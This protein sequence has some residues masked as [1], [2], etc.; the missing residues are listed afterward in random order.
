MGRIVAQVEVANP[1]QPE[2][3]S[4]FDALV[5]TGAS[6]L[7]LP[8]AW[9]DRLGQF[10]ATRTVKLEVAD[11]REV[12]GEVCGPVKIQIEGFDPIFSEV[13]FLDMQP[14][15]GVYEPLV[16][17]IVLEQSMAVVDMVGHRLVPVKHM[18][19]K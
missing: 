12:D 15:K 1:L 3:S 17:Y 11:Q 6:L 19:L 7:V 5:D 16:G 2:N 4:R 14:T 18:D 13:A 10:A 8:K 9:K